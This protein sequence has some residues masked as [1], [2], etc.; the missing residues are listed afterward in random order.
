[1]KTTINLIVSI[2]FI[3]NF[4]NAQKQAISINDGPGMFIVSG[5]KA[6][7]NKAI[8]VYYYKPKDFSTRSKVLLVIPGSGRNGDSYRDSWISIAEKHSV[9]IL[10]P[11]YPEKDYPYEDYHLGGIIKDAHTKDNVTF[12]QNSN[13]VFLN[14]EK[15]TF[16]MNSNKK[17]WIFN[18][19]DRIFDIAIKSL[20][21]SQKGYDVFGHSAGGQILHRFAIFQS[22]SK[23][24]RIIAANSGSYTTT[25][26][27]IAFPFGLKNT[28]ISIKDLKKIFAKKLVVFVGELDNEN[29]KRGLL[30][31]SKTVD[32]QGLHRLARAKYFF[33]TA[34]AK[35]KMLKFPFNWELKIIPD[36]GHNQRKMSKVAGDY[37]YP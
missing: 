14:E 24:N 5:G 23:A 13:Q 3:Y 16:T 32:K 26:S 33:N 34:K 7:K 37:L 19:L 27:E 6:K 28:E 30:L 17:A 11:S 9:L 22:K 2:L 10:S 35:A 15:V 29:E 21:T 8:S 36:I 18:D 12:V 4:V 25:D 20:K 1:M 31:R